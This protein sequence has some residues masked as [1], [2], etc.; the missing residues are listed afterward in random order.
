[1]N[2]ISCNA[3]YGVGGL[4][5]HMAT[6][7]EEARERGALSCYFA[8]AAK[9][10][11][12]AGREI[13]LEKYRWLFRTPPLRG[14]HGWKDFLAGELFDRA[15]AHALCPGER[16]TGFGGKSGRSF[17]RARELKFKQLALESAT[18]HVSNVRR[19][20][21]IAARRYPFEESWLNQA[22]HRKMLREY[23]EA[24]V[25]TVASEYARRTFAEA[26]TDDAK[27]QRRVIDVA[28]RFAPP[29]K[30]ISDGVF[31]IVY[32]GR[33]Q[34]SKGVPVLLEAFRWLNVKSAELVLVGGCAT[35]GMERYLKR[36]MARDRRIKLSPGDPLPHLHR[37][38]VLAHPSFEDGLGLSPLEALACGV[39]VIVTEDTGMKEFVVSGANGYVL[40]TGDIDALTDQLRYIRL[41]PLKGK[42]ET[43][44]MSCSGPGRHPACGSPGRSQVQVV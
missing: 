8:H 19:K 9:S 34:V 33:L 30:R 39:P 10:N 38:D 27:L 4:G 18:S 35:A 20:H 15:V 3:P 6:L 42:F 26:G 32:V 21:E 2:V 36:E 13:S 41:H 40:P 23:A 22:Q 31:R 37:A 1:M 7:V 29:P 28:P 44:R 25:I 17:R 43:Q 11:D 16:L 12:L 24:D 14:K 5:W